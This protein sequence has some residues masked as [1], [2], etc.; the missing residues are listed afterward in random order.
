MGK[1]W[2]WAGIGPDDDR[3]PCL[4]SSERRS[5]GMS[6]FVQTEDRVVG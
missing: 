4:V 2:G 5:R 3:G 6:G 1:D